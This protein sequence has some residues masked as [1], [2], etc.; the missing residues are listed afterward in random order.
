[1]IEDSNSELLDDELI[2]LVSS[3]A[4][5]SSQYVIFTNS[6]DDLFAI[7]VA[8]VEE[9]IMNKDIVITK[10]YETAGCTLGVSKIRDNI[11]TMLNFDDWLGIKDYNENELRLI[12][13][14]NYSNRR[15]GLVI[16]SVVGIQSFE[17]K[18]FFGHAEEDEKTIHILEITTGGRKRLC[19]VFDSD[20]MVMDVFPSIKDVE[21]GKVDNITQEMLD[22]K[23]ITK[24]VFFAEDS[25]LIQKS[26]KK[27][28]DKLNLKYEAFE[29]GQLMLNR[30]NEVSPN[31]ISLIITDI[32]MPVMD[33]MTFLSN[34]QKKQ[35]FAGIPILVNTNM[36]NE[37]VVST[38]KALGAVEV[39]RKLDLENL[40]KMIMKY[41]L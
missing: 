30:I 24:F 28:F 33:G 31:D 15:V 21:E 25:V 2:R 8:K 36:A 12:I 29:N 41:A 9:L 40:H 18:E 35:E 20:R 1:M 27:L 32:E 5:T 16:K 13:L 22:K 23:K 3:S 19:K 17:A 38:A 37:A 11:V 6:S 7:N 10:N 14:A 4:D 39:V 26:V 34:L